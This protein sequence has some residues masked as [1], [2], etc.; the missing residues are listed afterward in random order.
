MS[1]P[2]NIDGRRDFL[3]AFG[4]GAS[5]A[6]L[7]R[8]MSARSLRGQELERSERTIA[9][10]APANSGKMVRTVIGIDPKNIVDEYRARELEK[11]SDAEL[12]REVAGVVSRPPRR[13]LTS[14]T[15]HAPLEVMARY[16]LLRLVDPRERELARLQMAASGCV[17]GARV[18]FLPA[19]ATVKA[20]PDLTTATAEF[21]RTFKHG[22]PNGLEAL[23]VQIAGQFGI[24]SLVNVL[25]PLALPTLTGASHSHIGLWLLLRHGEPADGEDAVLLRAAARALAAEPQAQMRSFSGMEIDGS[26]PLRQSP[27]QIEATILSKLANPPKGKLNGQSIR[28]LVEA[29]EA[30]GNAD[31]LFGEFIRHDLTSAQ[32]DAAFRAVLRA[33]AHCMLQDDL[34][35]AKFGWTHCLTLPQ[36][37]CGLWTL[38]TNR[39]LALAAA[40]VWI[41]AYRSVLSQR[42]LD[43]S[44]KPP[45]P[46]DVDISEALHTSPEVAAARVWFAP[47]AELPGIRCA[48]ATQA[49]IRNDIHLV[50]YTRACL[51]LGSYDSAQCRLFLAAAAHL[52][53]LWIRECPR[54]TI[55]ENLLAGR[56]TP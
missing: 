54:A 44:W 45:R 55:H 30:T 9:M 25:T 46:N 14:F 52:S 32:I 39:K 53:A 40:L 13:G 2:M 31:T 21:S 20:F 16:G 11:L 8:V 15:L 34:S 17:Y 1:D 7:G 4:L 24:S 38:N 10:A 35:Q 28:A 42:A 22:D 36:S 29:G 50:K 49:A 3:K 51:D 12:Y 48:L 6:S 37:A 41:T 43:F 47:D 18:N 27:K 33:C 56:T 26:K 5:A 19:P 23:V